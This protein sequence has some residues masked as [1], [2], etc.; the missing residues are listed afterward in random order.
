MVPK[1]LCE[2]LSLIAANGGDDLYNG[3]L[4]KMFLEDVKNMGGI[5]T[6]EDLVKYE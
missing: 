1:K 3:T 2:T 4:S 5:I 6:A